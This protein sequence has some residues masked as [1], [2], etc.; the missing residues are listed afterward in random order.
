MSII[1]I[2]PDCGRAYAEGSEPT[3][4]WGHNFKNSIT[5]CNHI[6]E[7]EVDDDM[8]PILVVLWEKGY[9]TTYSCSGHFVHTQY[10]MDNNLC[11]TDI[12]DSMYIT[13]KYKLNHGTDLMKKVINVRFKDF[14]IRS[15][16]LSMEWENSDDPGSKSFTIRNSEK[17][18]SIA[19]HTYEGRE[20]YDY[21]TYA[22]TRYELLTDLM[23]FVV[24]L[25]DVNR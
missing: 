18:L 11:S 6:H 16:R 2:C 3:K 14:Q 15:D 24:N 21:A 17:Y 22:I 9:T 12:P 1:K 19:N 13:V 4:V 20:D 8:I 5:K 10:G 23:R 7:F 25:P